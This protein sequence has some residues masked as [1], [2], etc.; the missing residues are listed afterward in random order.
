MKY[1]HSILIII[2]ALVCLIQVASATPKMYIQPSSSMATNGSTFTVDVK[3]GPLGEE[4]TTAMYILQFDNTYLKVL[5]QT[6]GGFLSQG[7]EETKVDKNT[8]NNTAGTVTYGEYIKGEPGETLFGVYSPG[9]LA[10]ITFEVICDDGTGGLNITKPKL[11]V[12]IGRPNDIKVTYLDASG[13]NVYNGS[14]IISSYPRGDLDH[15]WVAADAVDVAMM[16]QAFVGD[17]IPNSEYD[18]D[19]NGNNADAVDVAMM[20]QAFVGDITL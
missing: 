18:L 7:G 5:S 11:A 13:I 12:V 20:I 15:N 1:T 3:V 10:S 14:Y 17:I 19:N 16:I 8:F 6:Q 4:V 2:I 9:T